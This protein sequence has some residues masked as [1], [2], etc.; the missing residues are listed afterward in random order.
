MGESLGAR[1]RVA[2]GDA[3]QEVEVVA[4]AAGQR[5]EDSMWL[6][7]NRSCLPPL[8]DAE[9]DTLV[10]DHYR[11]QARTLTGD[12]EAG[13]LKLAELRGTPT[14]AQATRWAQVKRAHVANRP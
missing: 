4:F 7:A 13:L 8:D 2:V 5:G 3:D 10:D 11:A 14:A 1:R 9:L 6:S 12:A